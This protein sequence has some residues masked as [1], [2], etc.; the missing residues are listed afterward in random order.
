MLCCVFSAVVTID[1]DIN[2]GDWLEL[3]ILLLKIFTCEPSELDSLL[4]W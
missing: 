2:I 1:G 4:I 3:K